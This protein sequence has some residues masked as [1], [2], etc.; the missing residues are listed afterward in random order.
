MTVCQNTLLYSAI[1]LRFGIKFFLNNQIHIYWKFATKRNQN[2]V[3]ILTRAARPLHTS[4]SISIHFFYNLIFIKLFFFRNITVHSIRRYFTL[5][6]TIHLINLGCGYT[7][8]I[9]LFEKKE[10]KI[11]EKKHRLIFT[12]GSTMN[13]WSLF[14]IYTAAHYDIVFNHVDNFIF[15]A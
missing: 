10:R 14:Y 2:D 13:G 1:V 3:D 9:Y 11:E 5:N 7:H 8:Y 4:C 15:Y 6:E 12:F